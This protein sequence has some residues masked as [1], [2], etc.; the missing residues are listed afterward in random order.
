M[1]QETAER[2]G[3]GKQSGRR[4][5]W[6]SLLMAVITLA[7]IGWAAWRHLAR[8]DRLTPLSVGS[9][10]PPL[11][12]LDL[13]KSERLLMTGQKGKVVWLFFWSADSARGRE[14]LTRL[15][16]FW[17]RLRQHE[18]FSPVAAAVDYDRPDRVRSVYS[19]MHATFPAY[20]A[21]PETLRRF[22]VGTSDPPLHVL[23][24]AGGQIAVLARAESPEALR[25]LAAQVQGWLDALDPR[26]P[27]RFAS[28]GREA[29]RRLMFRTKGSYN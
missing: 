20:L 3:S 1:D 29:R 23:I 13:D 27:S 9:H 26:G 25:R 21:P 10:V 8:A 2:P 11:A 15:K 6:L 24:D 18:R 19:E 16:P 12:L 7:A 5:D 28:A 14:E 4:V 22:A 17:T